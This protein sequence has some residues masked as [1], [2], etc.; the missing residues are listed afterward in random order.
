MY[1]IP[2]SQIVL[3]GIIKKVIGIS[4]MTFFI[5]IMAQSMNTLFGH[6][7]LAPLLKQGNLLCFQEVLT[8]DLNQVDAAW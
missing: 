3:I 5:S 8:T 1:G 7:D 6:V 2:R 4:P